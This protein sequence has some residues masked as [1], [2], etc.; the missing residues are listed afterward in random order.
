MQFNKKSLI[1][2]LRQVGRV[3][4]KNTVLPITACV[5]F[6]DKI[7]RATNTQTTIEVDISGI[8]EIGETFEPIAVDFKRFQDSINAMPDLIGITSNGEVLTISAGKSSVKLAGEK[9]SDFPIAKHNEGE[10]VK[11]LYSEFVA[12]GKEC[13]Q[14]CLDDDTLQPQIGGVYF[15]GTAFVATDKM[16]LTERLLR[17]PVKTNPIIFPR[18]VIQAACDFSGLK[19]G[20]EISINGNLIETPSARIIF[21]AIDARF[22]DYKVVIPQLDGMSRLK[23]SKA[24]AL[25]AINIAKIGA[26]EINTARIEI[27]TDGGESTISTH[28]PDLHN[29]AKAPFGDSTEFANNPGDTFVLG[30]NLSMLSMVLKSIPDD[31]I[32]LHFL[33]PNQAFLLTSDNMPGL[34]LMMPVMLL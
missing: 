31:D 19:E 24:K 5:Y 20:A 17:E 14:F 22:P 33:A 18:E 1:A 9:A 26:A 12:I 13:P 6:T 27:P 16:V 25:E 2:A 32:T 23:L 10:V 3:A 4:S 7:I 34:C 29:E 30:V 21:S 8:G 11:M 15:N 28:D